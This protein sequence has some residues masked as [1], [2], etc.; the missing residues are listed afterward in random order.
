M[1][2]LLT[3]KK[4]VIFLVAAVV[5]CAFGISWALLYGV[6][7][8][9]IVRQSALELSRQTALLSVSLSK[10]GLPG[11]LKDLARWEGILRGRVTLVDAGGAVLADTE[12]DPSGMDNHLSRPEVREALS[13]GEG[14]ALRY[15]ATTN[16]YYLYFARRV[17]LDGGRTAVIRSAYPLEYLSAAFAET[18]NRFLLYLFV[19]VALIVA[20]GA[21]MVR[22]FFRP[23]DRVVESAGK[24][25]QGEEVR[26]PIMA[27]PELQRLSNAL[28]GMSA[29]LRGTMEELRSEREDLSRIVTAL[30]VGVVL[31]DDGRR[32]RYMN[33]VATRLLAV[34]GDVSPGTPVE[35]ILPSGEM[36]GLI[37]APQEGGEQSRVFDLPELDGRCL[38]I[39][40][41]KTATGVL[42]VVTD[43]TEERRIEQSRR[44]FVADAGHEFQTPLT[45]IRAAAE[46]LLEAQEEETAEQRKKFLTSIITQQERMS[47]LVDDLLLLSR[48]ES[49]PPLR[50]EE[51]A[52]LSLLV[53][54]V[55]DQC[56][57]HPF[58]SL[59]AVE[60]DVPPQAPAVV[61]PADLTRA[62]SNLV[63]N[64]LK[65]VREKFGTSEG[66]RV[67][68]T[69][70]EDGDFWSILVAD[71]GPGISPETAP[72]LFERF[73]RGD[74]SRSR[75]EWGK[76]GYGL[77]LAI[78]K[79]ILIRA[80]GDLLFRP[81]ET[82][83]LFEARVPVKH[84]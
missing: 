1:T 37:E 5:F 16:M 54:G 4:K 10:E 56:R 22:L 80:G 38:G 60:T 17:S 31:L 44:D 11:F 83:A 2:A 29:Q 19:A 41:R 69:L 34:R 36:Y 81:S 40:S 3:L 58:A 6:V 82:G 57:S 43:L 50:D 32:V 67:T 53:T 52:D 15:S 59:I 42:L 28:D 70:R 73:R 76:G 49:E 12:R 26:F 8:D 13:G 48:M 21:G 24:I 68:L 35:R 39:T 20:F 27:E 71:N 78:A 74:A 9:G 25:A 18:R 14:K 77:G 75:G 84:A 33:G 45:A 63:E 46:Y 61:R 47:R 66:G 64:S 65:Y 7:R 51:E 72:V 23:L 79:R 62:L 30:P 55:A